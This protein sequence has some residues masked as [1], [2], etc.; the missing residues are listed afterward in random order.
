MSLV[1]NLLRKGFDFCVPFFDICL[2]ISMTFL[3]KELPLIEIHFFTILLRQLSAISLSTTNCDARHQSKSK[4][5]SFK[6]ESMTLIKLFIH[7]PCVICLE[8]MP[9][10]DFDIIKTPKSFIGNPGQPTSINLVYPVSRWIIIYWTTF[11]ICELFQQREHLDIRLIYF[12]L[13][14]HIHQRNV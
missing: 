10:C 12:Q 13:S 9:N 11:R 2:Y 1:N 5:S 6:T 8:K 14:Y 4:S 3:A 7:V